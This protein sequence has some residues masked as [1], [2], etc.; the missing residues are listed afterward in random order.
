MIRRDGFKAMSPSISGGSIPELYSYA[1]RV[2]IKAE[3]QPAVCICGRHEVQTI[4][5]IPA[6]EGGFAP[7]QSKA[8]AIL[9]AGPGG[10]GPHAA[11]MAALS[12]W[13]GQTALK[14]SDGSL[15]L[16]PEGKTSPVAGRTVLRRASRGIV[17]GWLRQN[18]INAGLNSWD[19]WLR[20]PVR[21]SGTSGSP[22]GRGARQRS[23]GPSAVRSLPLPSI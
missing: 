7:G 20:H 1:A 12:V 6:V 14:F 11:E 3:W 18:L 5:D 21:S 9:V 8:T 2:R 22:P 23:V 15:A 17:H 16:S 13:G 4:G 19:A 10:A